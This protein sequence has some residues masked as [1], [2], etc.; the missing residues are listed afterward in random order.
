MEDRTCEPWN[1]IIAEKISKWNVE[2]VVWVLLT[3]YSNMWEKEINW[4]SK[5][6]TGRYQNLKIWRILSLSILQ[7]M[8]KHVL[9]RTYQKCGWKNHLIKRLCMWT[10]S[11]IRMRLHQQK[12][13][14]A[15]LPRPVVERGRATPKSSMDGASIHSWRSRVASTAGSGVMLLPQWAWR[16]ENQT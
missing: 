8:G 5:R 12:H 9:E 2:D 15:K 10:T 11:G 16:A 7:K 4:R 6:Y 3:A 14:W 1:W 13:C